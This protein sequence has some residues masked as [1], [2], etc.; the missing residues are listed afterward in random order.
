MSTG[1]NFASYIRL[2]TKTDSTTLSDTNL[3]LLANMI[4]DD[5]S[6]DIVDLDEGYFG[7]PETTDLVNAQRE[8]PFPND[9]LMHIKKVEAVLNPTQKD[10]N[11]NPVWYDLH[12]FDLNSYSAMT[13]NVMM[14]DT[15]G[16]ELINFAPTTDE[17]KIQSV[18]ANEQGKCGYMIYR[19]ALWIFS[20]VLSGFTSG[21]NYLKI[22]S[23]AWPSD[24]SATTLA[25]TSDISIDPSTTD[26]A[27]PRILHHVWADKV[28]VAYKQTSDRAY[29]LDD[30]EQGIEKRYQN[31][32]AKLL[33]L[34]QDRSFTLTQPSGGHVWSDGFDL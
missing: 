29:Q 32:L 7:M 17:A 28:V 4:K 26:A 9:Q 19:N 16:N 10:Q 20:G 6:G 27:L 5:I 2:K 24:I 30:Y 22:W 18:F 34:N 33:G 23:Y 14:R 15:S 13:G 8:Y 11:G 3:C 21:N 31:A 25:S 1:V 12:E